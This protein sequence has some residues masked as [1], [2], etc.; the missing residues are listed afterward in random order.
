MLFLSIKKYFFQWP[1][2]HVALLLSDLAALFGTALL[3][4]LL[5]DFFGGDL[6]V[7]IY[8]QLSLFLLI[9]PFFSLTKDVYAA[10][11]PPFP[12]E[13]RTLAIS[14]SLAYLGMAMYLFLSRNT[15]VTSRLIFLIS[16][17]CSLGT[18]PLCRA[19]VRSRFADR[20]WWGTPTVLFGDAKNVQKVLRALKSKPASGFRPVAWASWDARNPAQEEDVPL[21]LLHGSQ[22]LYNYLR[23]AKE[24][25]AILTMDKTL[26]E[27]ER[28][29]SVKLASTHF[30]SVVV[31]P[32]VLGGE[33]L[34]FW[35]RPVEIGTLLGLK[36][37]QNLFDPRRLAVKRLMD[38]VFTV[39]GGVLFFPLL[40]IIALCIC[41]ESPGSPFFRQERIGREGHSLF[42]LKFRTMVK[43]AEQCL[44]DYLE[45]NPE[46][47]EEWEKDQKLRHDP[48][49]TRV[50]AF[51]RRTS[52]DEL[53][54]IWNV[55]RGEMSLV[56]PR[57][58]VSA[59]IEKYD[60]VFAAYVRVRPGITG[61]WQVSGR[62]DLSYPERVNLDNYYI[63]NWSTWLDLY[64]LAKTV[65]AVFACKGAY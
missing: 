43:D 37:R 55:L 4:T 3:V 25:C 38:I 45:A 36:L 51:L 13:L 9:S 30:Q 1:N 27:Y 64:I 10:T 26:S 29:E 54:Q 11:P 35:V 49:I 63:N 57:P 65:P 44:Q 47:R 59:E 22:A 8:M 32:E 41:I 42:V 24:T 18:V 23:Q 21:R 48:R 53:P 14:T 6:F 50:G 39:I 34:S 60:E 2:C 40:G 46:L 61:L 62:N 7:H 19:W 17:V 15:D 58:I 31:M 5:R 20:P 12:E 52:L 16:W 28:R 33:P 56:G